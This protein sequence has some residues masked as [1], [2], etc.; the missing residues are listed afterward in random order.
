M[1]NDDKYIDLLEFLP[2][3]IICGKLEKQF[4]L[5]VK[6]DN[7][8]LSLSY[9]TNLSNQ[10][11]QVGVKE[12]SLTI[13]RFLF[14]NIRTF[15]VIGLLQAE[16]GKTNNGNLSFANHEYKLINYVL[17]WFKKELEFDVKNWKWSIKLNMQEPTDLNYK[18][19]IENKVIKHWTE[20]TK[21]TL[22]QSYPKKVTYISNTKNIK[23]KDHDY[24][25]LVLEHKNNLFS[26]IIKNFVKIITY[27][28]IVNYEAQL[29]QG[30]MKA[31]IAGEGCIEISKQD[32]KFRVHISASKE[33]EKE[34][35]YQCLRKLG[36]ESIKYKGDKLVISKRKNNVQLLKQRLMTLSPAK[37]AKFLNMM[38]QYP[39]I[40]EETGYFKEKGKNVWNKIPQEIIDKIIELYNSGITNTK[41]IA[42]RLGLHILKVQRVLQINN[43]GKRITTIPE[44]KRMEI[45]K[46]VKDHPELNHEQIA[47]QF[48]VSKSAVSR[49]NLKY[50]L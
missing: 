45:A 6:L 3:N 43:L 29:I 40:K 9:I 38:Q 26:Q 44:S 47:K 19:K 2:Q 16:M 8:Y 42:E 46:Y 21:I 18:P 30:Y 23:L 36:V 24:G 31:I 41:E 27:R 49:A 32:K 37:Y 12:Y 25:T 22:E 17:Y 7:K 48:N 35:F 14:K 50:N 4:P 11:G 28:E 15:E 20:R 34:I 5:S 33:E 39:N 1:N 13:P 10:T